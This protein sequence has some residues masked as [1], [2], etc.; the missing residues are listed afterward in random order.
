[1][2]T[3]FLGG[4]D[5]KAYYSLL[6]QIVLT[7][8]VIGSGIIT[9]WAFGREFIEKVVKDLLV[10]PLPREFIVAAKL[11]VLSGWALM[12]SMVLLATAMITGWLIRL[13]GW[14][15][16]EFGHFLQTY[17][18][19][20]ALNILLITPVAFVASAGR[21][22]MLPISFVILVM[23][24]TQIIFVGIPS[25]TY[26]FPWALPALVSG[27]AGQAMP[28]AGFQSYLMYGMLVVGSLVLTNRWWK[29]ADHH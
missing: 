2:K 27:V 13:P 5:W 4:S 19:C 3:S 18:A 14:N 29:H 15:L 28:Q 11:I 12:L 10:M 25:I 24:L 20:S 7:V 8:A 26:W 17:L 6:L 22:Y 16:A 23:I 1:M 9:S 21:G